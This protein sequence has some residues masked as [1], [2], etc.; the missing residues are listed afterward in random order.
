MAQTNAEKQAIFRDRQ[1]QTVSDQA[2]TIASQQQQIVKLTAQLQ[3]VT[4]E[5]HDLEIQLL[6][7]KAKKGSR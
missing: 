6:K 7:L 4:Q 1:K 5:K 3:T 2:A